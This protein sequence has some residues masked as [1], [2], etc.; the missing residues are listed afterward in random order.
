MRDP[1]MY[2]WSLRREHWWSG[3]GGGV[4]L[5]AAVVW[6]V[7]PAAASASVGSAVLAE[8]GIAAAVRI[9][10]ITPADGRRYRGD[11][12]LAQRGV[13]FLPPLRARVLASQLAQITAL[14]DSYTSPRALA[15]FSQLEENVSYLQTHPI[16]SSAPDVTGPDGVVYRW[17]PG[18]G[19][20]F[21]PLANFAQLNN[22][23]AAKNIEGARAL[24]DALVAR[25]IPRGGSLLWEYA[26]PFGGGRPPW[27]SGLAQ[28]VAA[29]A[30][31]RASV[32][33]GDPTLLT[34]AARA[35]AAIP[36]KLDLELSTGPWI[37]LYG[38]NRE[39]VL[40]AQL[41]AILSLAEYA[42]TAS[43]PGAASLVQA[44]TAAARGLLPRFD[45]GDWS[46][47]ELG[48]AY[49]S[50]G[51]QVFVTTLLSALAKQTQDPFWQNAA[52]QFTN[53]TYQ[54]P[55]LTQPTPPPQIVTFPRPLDGWLDTASI[56]VTL[57]KNATLTLAVAGK[58][59][60]WSHLSR[61]THTLTWKP[62]P[63]VQPGVYPVTVQATDFT[64][65]R[66]TFKLAPI[67][68]AWDTAPPPITAQINGTTLSWTANDPGT[69][70]L[71]LKLD[72]SDPTGSQ[73]PQQLDLGQQPPTGSY[74]LT[75]PPGTWNAALEATN[76]AALTT[77]IP[78][79][80]LT[81]PTTPP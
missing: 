61:G 4:A 30:L 18:Q 54:P 53:Y 75:I 52:T 20:E 59:L 11:V 45:T 36:G 70:W 65:K 3:C 47:Y 28:A 78:L 34:A 15:L 10:W 79:P 48:G 71:A 26:F 2:R 9:G 41:Q 33:L 69:P 22:L 72:L 5:L 51:Y 62:G 44:M 39:I 63:D 46:R 73:P 50:Q 58:V 42:R 1:V 67:T 60:T 57:S 37:R 17:F 43:D 81:G 49:A 23:A 12:Y 55:Q 29:Q 19:F 66:A 80:T 24:A 13:R 14:W 21:H 7:A 8:R 40:N 38:F 27:A 6:L 56:P 68:V 77:T 74:Q 64:G 35:Y 32:A 25:A 16:P 31:A 76:S